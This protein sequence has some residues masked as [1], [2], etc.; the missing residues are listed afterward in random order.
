MSS[1]TFTHAEVIRRSAQHGISVFTEKPV[2]ETA[3]KIESLFRISK[4][5]GIH[6]CCGFQR[7]FDTSYTAAI[8]ALPRIGTPVAAHLTFYDHP[9]S[10]LDF[11]LEG[12]NIAMD[13]APHDIDYIRHALQDEVVSI[14]ASGSSST[15]QLKAADVYDNA[16]LMMKFSKGKFD[17][18]GIQLCLFA[19]P[20][21]HQELLPHSS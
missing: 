3:L 5:A 14:Y 19:H 18:D 11:L 4:E 10:P 12:G 20:N 2:D 6:L 13:L 7:R 15:D 16:T 9:C 8:E 17:H 21:I 1:P